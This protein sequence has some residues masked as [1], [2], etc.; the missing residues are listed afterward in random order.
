MLTRLSRVLLGASCILGM[1]VFTTH[2]V[3]AQQIPGVET[4]PRLPEAAQPPGKSLPGVTVPGPGGA[5]PA[6]ADKLKITLNSLTFDGATVYDDATLKGFY[7]DLLGKQITLAEV[8][9]VAE[10]LQKRYR[11]DGYVLSRVLVP[12]Q[13]AAGGNFRI[14]VI[15]GSVKQIK[16][17]GAEG[18][19]K[20]IAEGLLAPIILQKPAR[21]REIERGLLSLNDLPGVTAS[22]VL[23]AN[24]AETG[25]SDLIVKVKL[26]KQDEF[27]IVNNRG[28]RFT[29]PARFTL[30]YRLNSLLQAGD[31]AEIIGM[32]T[33]QP[34]EQKFIQAGYDFLLRDDGM[35]LAVNASHSPSEPGFTL[36]PLNVR[37]FS[38]R[39]SVTLSYPFVRSRLKN[40]SGSIG[41]DAS[42]SRTD[43]AGTGLTRDRLRV[44][45]AVGSYD[46]ADTH[47]GRNAVSLILRQG[48]PVFG[49]TEKGQSF[50]S[51]TDG[52]GEFSKFTVEA[53]RNQAL[54]PGLTFLARVSGQYSFD[55]LL[56]DEE[57]RL[58]GETYGR[59]YNP[60]E[61]A[62]DHGLA[63]MLELRK[64]GTSNHFPFKAYQ[65]YAFHDAGIVW[66]IDPTAKGHASLASA[67]VG[68]R[69][70]LYPGV[71]GN[72]ELARP[73]TRSLSTGEE[74][75][76]TGRVFF[77]LSA[78][79]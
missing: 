63:S 36:D 35:R 50:A 56:A 16:I 76:K 54:S 40:I 57:F 73:L 12:A 9:A 18:K 45:Q 10:A 48:L 11:A 58:G 70:Q 44:I 24:N 34:S 39:G 41:F 55:A 77:Q 62:G 78:N 60:S 19:L 28:S 42:E 33:S 68:I 8:F 51:R 69:T 27:Y 75:R 59:G 2:P 6:G 61:L 49:A 43:A 79:F 53:S 3:S 25:A 72:L 23:S 66:N 7:G 1:A 38:T 15:E 21:L 46:A 52:D 71:V 13:K 65:M 5:A 29:G 20:E 4:N 67:G 37:S 30:G 47:N 74:G 17:E 31:V 22:G 32:S 14:R 26:K 64:D